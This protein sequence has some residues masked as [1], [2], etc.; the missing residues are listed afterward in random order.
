MAIRKGMIEAGVVECVIALPP[1][2]FRSTGIP[3]MVW[4]LC[5][6]DAAS[7]LSETLFI[8]ARDLGEM[9]EHAKRRLV[10]DDI[11]R[12]V[13]EYRRWRDR[14]VTEFTGRDGF[15]R[16]VNHEEVGEND[17]VLTPARYT[18]LAA[19]RPDT[20][21]FVADLDALRGEFDDLSKRAEEAHAALGARVAALVA[22][23]RPAGDGVSV[24][25][26]SIC[27]VLLGPGTVSRSGR[28]PL[29][30]PLILPRN[31]KNDRIMHDDLDVVPPATAE[32]MARYQLIAGDIVSARAGTLGRYGLVL[33]DQA[34]WL[35]GPGCVRFRPNDQVNSDYL[36]SY[37]GSPAARHWL[38]EHATGSAIQHVN[39]A[40][41]RAMPIW[42]PSL[43]TQH[44]IL[45]FLSP[46]HAAAS[47]HSRISATTRE[48]HDLL[49]PALMAPLTTR[50][51]E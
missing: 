26:D 18:G 41:L 38:T 8:D 32:R 33:D 51:V 35:L 39:A 48:L 3:T 46:L 9:V 5:G 43:A 1:Q 23:Q 34:G 49:V 40:T 6:A 50:G 31:I 16:S 11:A 36:T 19:E 13:N 4:I 10:G 24:R 2:L 28:Q 15:S 42:L 37:L 45:E 7:S 44:A 17:H 47:I 12:I 25:L 21:R 29:W 22:G 20:A 14:S 27:D 30:T